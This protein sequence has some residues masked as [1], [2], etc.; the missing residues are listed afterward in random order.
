MR[1]EDTSPPGVTSATARR[2]DVC[3]WLSHLLGGRFSKGLV[4]TVCS[5]AAV[6]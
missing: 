5:G 4:N 2:Q 3:E 6:G 1:K